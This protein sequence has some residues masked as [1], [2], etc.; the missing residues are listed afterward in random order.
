[1]PDTTFYDVL[2][3]TEQAS[4]Q[5]IAS[6]YRAL[7]AGLHPDKLGGIPEA[8]LRACEERLSEINEAYEILKRPES[9]RKYDKLVAG[10]RAKEQAEQQQAA[11]QA[12]Y[13]APPAYSA[14][15][16]A[17]SVPPKPKKQRGYPVLV[18]P[19]PQH[20]LYKL[21]WPKVRIVIGVAVVLAFAWALV[22]GRA[23]I[24]SNPQW[25]IK[26]TNPA[27]LPHGYHRWTSAL[28]ALPPGG[29][30]SEFDL[31]YAIRASEEAQRREVG[32]CR[33]ERRD[34]HIPRR[35]RLRDHE[36]N[37]GTQ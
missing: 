19:R 13:Q 3:V 17:P 34:R 6:A 29:W 30:K 23:I 26:T 20:D 11:H 12:Q 27:D 25:G 10:E 35:E 4:P 1:M 2:G 14:P 21:V 22:N 16:V 9:R 31:P 7:A 5:E 33:I 28:F 36:R 37:T 8:A 32:G 18:Y 24:K 15:P